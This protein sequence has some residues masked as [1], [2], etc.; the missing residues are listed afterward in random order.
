MKLPKG[1]LFHFQV[2]KQVREAFIGKA[3]ARQAR[4]GTFPAMGITSNF[5]TDLSSAFREKKGFNRPV[6]NIAQTGIEQ[7]TPVRH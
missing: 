3:V 5:T 4:L 2:Q 1:V 7:G 6:P